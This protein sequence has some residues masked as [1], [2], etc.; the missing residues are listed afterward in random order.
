MKLSPETIHHSQV[1]WDYHAMSSPVK[2]ADCILVLG[3]HDVRPAEH[4]AK[5][6]HE[7][8][9]ALV[10]CSG[11]YGKVTRDIW[12]EPESVHFKRILLTHGVPDKSILVEDKATNTGENFTLAKDLVSRLGISI[13][14]GIIVTKPYMGR[15]A[16]ATGN[17]QWPGVAWQVSG[18]DVSLGKYPNEEVSLEQ[19]INLMVGDLQRIAIYPSKG[20]QIQQDIPEEVWASYRFLVDA[21]FDKFVIGDG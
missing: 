9:S 1:L 16:F 11:G 6:Y 18:P 4:A 13:S 15:R 20:F 19:T 12:N 14:T 2:T 3:S 10:I 5:L 8:K 21:G 7:G 17:K